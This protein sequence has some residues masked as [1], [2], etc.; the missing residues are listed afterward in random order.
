ME[1][2]R[3][4]LVDDHEVVR[5]GLKALINRQP[6]LLVVGEA[7][8][9]ASAVSQ[10]LLL[11]PEVV[12]MDIRL[13]ATSGIEACRQITTELPETRVIMLTSYAEEDMFFT[14]VRIGAAGYVL[15]QAGAQ[16]LIRAIESV[17]AGAT[18]LDPGE[19]RNALTAVTRAANSLEGGAF[20]GLNSHEQRVLARITAGDTNREIAARLHLGEGTVRNYV[21]NILEKLDVANRAEASAYA[22]K[23]NLPELW[24][25]V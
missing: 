9:A 6:S 25:S 20:A 3:I 17:L 13:G 15:K 22:T 2:K 24:G 4:L 23:Y 7:T 14:A 12:V 10:A 11:K 1:R 5:L 18:L 19:V 16:A 8:D 21:S